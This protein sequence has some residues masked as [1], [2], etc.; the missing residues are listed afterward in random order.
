MHV[1]GHQ[2]ISM[3]PATRLA[4]ILLQPIQIE[5]VILIRY[6]TGLSVIT[7]LNQVQGD[8]R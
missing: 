5:T 3:N 4:R 2:H 7:A 6:E 8:M 1:V